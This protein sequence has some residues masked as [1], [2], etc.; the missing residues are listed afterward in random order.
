MSLD[1]MI[2]LYWMKLMLRVSRAAA[3]KNVAPHF[4]DL[5]GMGRRLA[6]SPRRVPEVSADPAL[7]VTSTRAAEVRS[8]EWWV[9]IV[10][11]LESPW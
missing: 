4:D 9:R 8:T 10:R 11:S 1:T 6:R 5:E 7:G 2:K 3:E